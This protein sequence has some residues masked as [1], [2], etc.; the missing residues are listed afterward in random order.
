[1]ITLRMKIPYDGEM[2]DGVLVYFEKS[3]NLPGLTDT[4]MVLADSSLWLD[5]VG[6][7]Q[8]DSDSADVPKDVE[9]KKLNEAIYDYDTAVGNYCE[10]RIT[11]E[12]FNKMVKN[13]IVNIQH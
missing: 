13:N 4:S 5:I 8:L 9:G 11:E 7:K 2:Y 1:M 3:D 12:D 6:Q 10:G